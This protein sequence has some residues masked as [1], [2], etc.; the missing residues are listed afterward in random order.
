MKRY[1]T[2]VAESQQS[3]RDSTKTHRMLERAAGIEPASSAWKAEVIAIIRCPLV[4]QTNNLKPGK[5]VEGEGFE[6]SKAEPSDLQSDPFGRSGTPPDCGVSQTNKVRLMHE[7]RHFRGSKWR[8]ATGQLLFFWLGHRK[9][10]K[11]AASLWG[12]RLWPQPPWC[13][14]ALLKKGVLHDDRQRP[15]VSVPELIP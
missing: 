4:F 6:P 1:I 5:L 10:G 2:D 7:R 11:S 13:N 14:V 8:L 15:P 9:I 12:C 3:T